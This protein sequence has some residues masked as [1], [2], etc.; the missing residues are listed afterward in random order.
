MTFFSEL[1]ETIEKTP[2]QRLP[3]VGVA[4]AVLMY[5]PRRLRSDGPEAR[6][7]AEADRAY[8]RER[9]FHAEKRLNEIEARIQRIAAGVPPHN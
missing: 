3:R 5:A 7:Q 9:A 2:P 4:S 6:Q 1:I 8:W